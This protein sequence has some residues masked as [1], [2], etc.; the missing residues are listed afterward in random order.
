ML[1]VKYF[2]IVGI[3]CNDQLS[4][5]GLIWCFENIHCNCSLMVAMNAYNAFS[6]FRTGIYFSC[7]LCFTKYMMKNERNLLVC[8][9]S[10]CQCLYYIKSYCMSTKRAFSLSNW[11]S[12]IL[13]FVYTKPRYIE[14]IW[15]IKSYHTNLG[16]VLDI[17]TYELG[18]NSTQLLK[19]YQAASW[20]SPLPLL[21]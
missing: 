5:L 3:V 10:E 9:C 1:K 21:V 18:S 17:L 16:D 13:L 12:D 8:F 20:E 15:C 19:Q 7:A 4:M 6:I 14:M 11:R 2:M